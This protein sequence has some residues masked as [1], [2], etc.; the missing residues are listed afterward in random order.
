[1]STAVENTKI[2]VVDTSPAMLEVLK[3]FAGKHGYDLD[4]HS[5][6]AVAT[7][8][9]ND[10]FKRFGPDY[11]CVM[12]GW[13]QGD[14]G[15]VKELLSSLAS[16]D[17]QDLPLLIV[18]QEQT[19]ELSALVKRR[20]RTRAL[21]W[22]D[23]QSA[24]EI[25]DRLP[26]ARVAEID[27]KVQQAAARTAKGDVRKS[28]LL[29]DNAP[30]I[31]HT[32]KEMMQ[33]NGYQVTIANSS[34]AARQILQTLNFDLV[35]TDYH[36]HSGNADQ[37]IESFCVAAKLANRSAVV[38]VVSGKY[39]DAVIKHSLSAGAATCLFKSESTELLFARIDALT[40]NLMSTKTSENLQEPKREPVI[41]TEQ[42]EPEQPQVIGAIAKAQAR[43]A[44]TAKKQPDKKSVVEESVDKTVAQIPVTKNESAVVVQPDQSTVITKPVSKSEFE[45][46]LGLVLDDVAD[47]NP[48]SARY[49]V[50]VRCSTGRCHWR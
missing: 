12:L 48:S 26:V 22:K 1:M 19:P 46:S 21:L 18:C 6:P 32:L 35:V 40:R 20:P 8:A 14:S 15:I 47:N 2:L 36:L 9:L 10:R 4:S 25:I 39:T 49:S 23:Y 13:P 30:S 16:P 5:D 28:A 33:A 24:A 3:N 38:A 37:G 41:K 11:R 45:R 27:K 42:P 31:C 7:I 50:D 17:H 44:E 34:S 43:V 29:A